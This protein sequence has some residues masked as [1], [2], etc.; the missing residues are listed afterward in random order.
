MTLCLVA[1]FV[2][3]RLGIKLRGRR[4]AALA[5]DVDLIRRHLRIAKPAVLFAMLGFGGGALSSSLLRGWALFETFH[6]FAA[7][8]V[9]LSFGAT[10]WLGLKAQRGEGDPGLHGLLGVL[11]MLGAALTALAGFV[12]LP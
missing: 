3:L 2:A 11:S 1:L 9:V 6:A 4:L 5:P 12:L 10:A 8:V 7:L